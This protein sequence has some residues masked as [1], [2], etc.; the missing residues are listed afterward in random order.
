MQIH[1]FSL[2]AQ[3]KAIHGFAATLVGCGS[4]FFWYLAYLLIIRRARIDKI[5]GMP[6]V[7]MCV[8]TTWEFIYTF[9]I[10]PP[11]SMGQMQVIGAVMADFIWF[12]LDIGIVITW[13]RYWRAGSPPGLSPK[14]HLPALAATLAASA[15]VIYGMQV[16]FAQLPGE[17]DLPGGVSSFLRSLVMSATFVAMVLRRNSTAGQSLAIALTMLLGGVMGSAYM[18]MSSS[19]FQTTFW[20]TLFVVIFLLDTLYAVLLARLRGAPQAA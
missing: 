10:Q 4:V 13:L 1:F 12:M 3:G 5:Y 7:A 16:E 19:S 6:F 14:W 18:Y 9:R 2:L 11:A 15:A 20:I 17:T 8:D